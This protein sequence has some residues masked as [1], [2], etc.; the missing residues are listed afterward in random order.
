MDIKSASKT[1]R[2]FQENTG[3]ALGDDLD[4]ATADLESLQFAQKAGV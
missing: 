2:S 4:A 3:G 1:R